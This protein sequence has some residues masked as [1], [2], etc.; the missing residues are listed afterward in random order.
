M[1]ATGHP[2]IDNAPPDWRVSTVDEVKSSERHACVA[3]PFGSSISS[4]FFTTSGVPVIRGSNL[5]IGLE[6]FVARDFV[7]VSEET[8]GKF[9]AQTVCAGDLVFTCW[10]TIGQ[11]GL[12]PKDGPFDRYI[13]SNKQ[14]KLR[15]DREVL[16]PLFAFYFFA[17]PDS[18]R[19]VQ[20][21]AIGSA[22]P[23][24]NLGILKS[25]PVLIPPLSIQQRIVSILSAYDDLIEVNRRQITLLEEMARGLFEEWF[26]RFRFPGHEEVPILDTPDGP[27]PKGWTWGTIGEV[28]KIIKSGS[29]PSR[30]ERTYWEDGVLEWFTTGELNNGFLFS[31]NE[32][33][34]KIA[35]DTNKVRVFPVGTVFIALYGAT[36]G[37]LG[38]AA[39]ECS[40]NQAALGLVPDGVRMR[41][42]QLFHTLAHLK[43]WFISVGQG[44]AQQN[45][46]KEKVAAARVALPPAGIS[47]L[48]DCMA[49]PLWELRSVVER[50]NSLLAA[51]RD[52][53]LPRLIS[54]QLSVAQAERELE[55][56]A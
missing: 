46:S 55:K 42:W 56:A 23:G 41:R 7:F 29:T 37:A 39:V 44:A 27:L 33:V 4:K 18:V 14:L 35:V 19:Y 22:V 43:E 49:A 28:S 30:K 24:I 26:V 3:G 51:S 2:L 11:V 17:A 20:D 54:G 16:D 10:G 13:I 52:L 47:E 32:R 12:I 40:S 25:L 48:F 36:I 8:A 53:L 9:S 5:T 50:Q 6:R 1:S 38:I 15:V 31:A 21:R 45:I 34:S